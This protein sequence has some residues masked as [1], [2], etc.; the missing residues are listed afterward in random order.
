V[1][2]SWPAYLALKQTGPS[3]TPA[4]SSRWSRRGSARNR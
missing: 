4:S 1:T 2:R 3:P